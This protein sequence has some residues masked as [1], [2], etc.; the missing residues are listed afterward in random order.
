MITDKCLILYIVLHIWNSKSKQASWKLLGDCSVSSSAPSCICNALHKTLRILGLRFPV[1]LPQTTH[2]RNKQAVK[3]VSIKE[4]SQPADPNFMLHPLRVYGDLT[5][6]K[7]MPT[8]PFTIPGCSASACA[9]VRKGASRGRL[10]GGAS[11]L[12]APKK[13]A[14]RFLRALAETHFWTPLICDQR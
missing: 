12:L 10:Q 3:N 8:L 7:V 5:S 11:G 6:P 14:S 1:K 4:K 9:G 2:L 13:A